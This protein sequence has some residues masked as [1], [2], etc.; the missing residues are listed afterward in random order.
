MGLLRLSATFCFSLDRTFRLGSDAAVERKK[1]KN[2]HVISS[3]LRLCAQDSVSRTSVDYAI[4]RVRDIIFT[5]ER[6]EF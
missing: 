1:K 4:T 3:F 5:A 6:H 2:L